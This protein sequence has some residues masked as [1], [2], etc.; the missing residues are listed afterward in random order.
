MSD[1]SQ[2]IVPALEKV[3]SLERQRAR[4]LHVIL[5]F[6]SIYIIWGSTYLAIRYAVETIPPLYTAGIRH[7]VA[8]TILLAWALGKGLR[9]TAA[10]IRASVVI[11]FLFFLLGHGSLH[12]AER[13]VPSGTAALLI[14]IEP[15]FVFLLSS[16][17]ARVW[18]LN[19]LLVAGILLG[20]I[21]VGVLVGGVDTTSPRKHAGSRSD[22]VRSVGLVGRDHLLAE[23]AL[24]GAPVVAL[25]ALVAVRGS[26]V[27]GYGN[28]GRRSAGV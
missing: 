23:V 3:P 8:G 12:W 17:A 22:I 24:V 20:L 14:A 27:V 28:S 6:L 15:I 2:A 10:Q 11:G 18:R 19:G 26:D 13:I 7:L 4:R 9:P 25:S 16:M 5:A 1:T 21:G